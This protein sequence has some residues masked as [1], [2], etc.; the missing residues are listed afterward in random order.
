MEKFEAILSA[1]ETLRQSRSCGKVFFYSE[2][3]A[4]GMR[5][6]HVAV[7]AEARCLIDFEGR[8]LE[9]AI[10]A[11]MQTPIG[12]VVLLTNAALGP[13]PSTAR[14]MALTGLM[15]RLRSAAGIEPAAVGAAPPAPDPRPGLP[16]TTRV[17]AAAPAHVESS[18]APA[19]GGT[20]MVGAIALVGAVMAVLEEYFGGAAADRVDRL[21]DRF[22]PDQQ[23]EAF[24]AAAEQQLAALVGASTS[25]RAFDGVRKRLGLR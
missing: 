20:S 17:S 23:P 14:T 4:G 25:A 10:E 16:E 9:Q 6:G 12:R 15:D 24:L 19:S 18:P 2:P 5:H 7:H 8:S 1:L 21:T 3:S 22:P 11:L 13:A